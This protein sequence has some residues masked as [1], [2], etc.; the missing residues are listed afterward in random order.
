MPLAHWVITKLRAYKYK[1][2]PGRIVTSEENKIGSLM[3]PARF[4][5]PTYHTFLHLLSWSMLQGVF[6]KE[7]NTIP[8]LNLATPGKNWPVQ[9]LEWPASINTPCINK[10]CTT[11][12]HALGQLTTCTSLKSRQKKLN[13]SKN[14]P[15]HG[16]MKFFSGDSLLQHSRISFTYNTLTTHLS[17]HERCP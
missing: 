6:L 12:L 8:P 10:L 13:I 2:Q 14:S 16:H 9:A 7:H 17:S 1:C 15:E 5:A 11:L 3:K 4:A